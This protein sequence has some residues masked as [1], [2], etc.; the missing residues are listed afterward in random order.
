[1]FWAYSFHGNSM[2]HLMSYCGLVDARISASEKGLCTC[3]N[4]SK[5]F[6]KIFSH[7]S[8]SIRCFESIFVIGLS[9]TDNIDFWHCIFGGIFPRI[10]FI[11]IVFAGC[12]DNYRV[13]RRNGFAKPCIKYRLRLLVQVGHEKP[14]MYQSSWNKHFSLNNV[15]VRLLIFKVIFLCWKSVESFQKKNLFKIL[16]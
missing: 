1:M 5:I 10:V 14:L 2:N 15:I 4:Q 9:H 12:S 8:L 16:D 11:W 3:T 6:Q 13:H 7:L